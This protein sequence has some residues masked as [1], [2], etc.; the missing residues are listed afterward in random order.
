M[1]IITNVAIIVITI[2][3]SLITLVFLNDKRKSDSR[4]EERYERILNESME[5]IRVRDQYEQSSKMPNL[6]GFSDNPDEFTT[7]RRELKDLQTELRRNR[8]STSANLKSVDT[9]EIVRVIMDEVKQYF[10]SQIQPEAL[11]K[12]ILNEIIEQMSFDHFYELKEI[13][14]KTKI[15]DARKTLMNILHVLRTPISGMKINLQKL[16]QLND[17]INQEIQNRYIQ[18]EDALGVI[19][20]NMRAL[21][22]HKED[23]NG[24]RSNLKDHIQRNIRL[25]LLTADKKINLNIDRFSKEIFLSKNEMDKVLLCVACV[26]ENAISFSPDNSEVAIAANKENDRVQLEITNFGSNIPEDIGNSIFED[27]FTSRQG[28]SG[29]GLSLART[30]VTDKLNGDISFEN[31]YNPDGVKFHLIF[32][33]R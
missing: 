4:N 5:A 20:A 9:D 1:D 2:L 17:P 15:E 32:E 31:I 7:F 11:S 8:Y 13:H 10:N 16:N 23:D 26:V 28:G 27:G 18:I 21:G 25:L 30:I 24:E 3:F 19:E 29:I 22:A 33:V 6:K 14:Y 12:I